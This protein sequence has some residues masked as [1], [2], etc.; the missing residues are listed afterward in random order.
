MI[1]AITASLD[2]SFI[3]P[4]LEIRDTAGIGREV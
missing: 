3:S 2:V 1:P 4:P